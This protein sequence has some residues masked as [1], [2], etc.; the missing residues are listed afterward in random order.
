MINVRLREETGVPRTMTIWLIYHFKYEFSGLLFHFQPSS[1]EYLRGDL[2]A[3]LH[4]HHHHGDDGVRDGEM[5]H[6]VVD[7]CPWSKSTIVVLRL[8]SISRSPCQSVIVPLRTNEDTRVQ[9]GSNLKNKVNFHFQN[10][11]RRFQWTVSL[12]VGGRKDQILTEAHHYVGDDNDPVACAG[13]EL[14]KM[15][16]LLQDWIREVGWF[17][18]WVWHYGMSPA[19]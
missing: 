2:P 3:G 17:I 9:K 11:A 5:E 6:E 7:I 10:F 18:E 12:L 19:D 1:P 16:Y 8:I 15:I 13:S 14:L 4:G